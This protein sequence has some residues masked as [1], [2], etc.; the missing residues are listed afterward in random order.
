MEL[1][2]N[3]LT[4]LNQQTVK[5]LEDPLVQIYTYVLSDRFGKGQVI[6]WA[7]EVVVRHHLYKK[8]TLPLDSLEIML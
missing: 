6:P 4:T 8:D 5:Y 3:P 2:T 7:R 1:G